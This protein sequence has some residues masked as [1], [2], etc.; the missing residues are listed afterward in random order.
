MMGIEGMDK[1]FYCPLKCNLQ[2]DD[3]GGQSPYRRVDSLDWSEQELR[4]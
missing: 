2:V 4:F 3:S 1:I